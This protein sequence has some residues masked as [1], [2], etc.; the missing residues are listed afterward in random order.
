MAEIRGSR[1]ELNE[2]VTPVNK[3]F[4]GFAK[5]F[6]KIFDF[7]VTKLRF[8]RLTGEITKE[9]L[10]DTWIRKPLKSYMKPFT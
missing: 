8:L 3:G 4:A 10:F 1:S 7:F 2:L 6:L 5:I 9:R